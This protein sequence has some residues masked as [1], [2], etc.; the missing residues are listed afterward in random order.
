MQWIGGFL[1]VLHAV[2]KNPDNSTSKILPPSS[3]TSKSLRHRISRIV[4]FD[5]VPSQPEPEDGDFAHKNIINSTTATT[6]A[7]NKQDNFIQAKYKRIKGIMGQTM[8]T[9]QFFLYGRKHFTK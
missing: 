6:E 9:S 3:S 5:K 8:S 4:L 7:N 2:L 1:L